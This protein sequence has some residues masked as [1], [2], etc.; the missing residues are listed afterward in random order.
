MDF[1][2]GGTGTAGG[3]FVFRVFGVLVCFEL[4]L[5]FFLLQVTRLIRKD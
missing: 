3:F 1:S 2:T 5:G 4:V